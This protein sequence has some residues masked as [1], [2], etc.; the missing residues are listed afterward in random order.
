MKRIALIAA[1]LTAGCGAPAWQT[2]RLVVTATAEGVVAADSAVVEAYRASGC[3]ETE[4]VEELRR[5]VA[6][7]DEAAEALGLA[8][9]SVLVGET[10][11]DA[12][13]Q[14]GTEPADWQDWLDE[15][16]QLAARIT[17]LVDRVADV[18]EDLT[19][20]ASVLDRYLEQHRGG[21]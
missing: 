7:L 19:H 4:D 10:L 3:G 6:Q 2:A 9:A 21:E 15:A 18:P 16:G 20:W 5:C 8:R 11:V 13:E 12:W 1:L 17:A 14:G